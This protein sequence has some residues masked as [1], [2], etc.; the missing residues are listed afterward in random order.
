MDLYR[1]ESLGQECKQDIARY[2]PYMIDTSFMLSVN[3]LV[4]SH[5][6]SAV[7]LLYCPI[8]RITPTKDRLARISCLWFQAQVAMTIRI[9]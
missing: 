8:G 1:F 6:A 3:E 7:P 9:T 4:I 5:R 2:T